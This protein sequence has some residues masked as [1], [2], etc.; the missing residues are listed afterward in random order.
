MKKDEVIATKKLPCL[1]KRET[2]TEEDKEEVELSTWPPC[3][4]MTSVQL[5]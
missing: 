5:L 2:R 1:A 4:V 3:P